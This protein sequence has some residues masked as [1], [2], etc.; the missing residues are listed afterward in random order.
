M[1]ELRALAAFVAEITYD[2]LPD[3]V[4][5]RAKLVLR[6]TVGVI[7]GG[8]EE[9]EVDALAGYAVES[10]P[11]L[12]TLYGHGGKVTPSWAA[13]VHG[14]AGTTLEM[15][16]GHAYAR[17]HAAI[18]ALPPALA[19]AQASHKGGQDTL[20]AFVA[21]Y[22][23]AART[24]IATRLREHV[25]PFGA[26]G[27][28]GAAAVGAR[29]HQ[30]DTEATAGALEVAASYAI[31][32][33]FKTAYQG[34]NVRNTYA[35]LVNRLGLLAADLYAV[36]FRGEAGG[37]QTAFG[38]ILGWQFDPTALVDGLGERFEIL[39]GYFKPYSACRY[40][41]A[42][43]DAVLGLRAAGD[44]D[45]SRVAAIEVQ[46]YDIAAHLND[47][48]PRTALAGRFSLPFVTAAT[49]ATGG[50]GPEIF[51]PQVLR[52][53]QI[54][55]LA[56]RVTVQEDPSF[57]AMTPDQRAARVIV[58]LKNGSTRENTVTGSKG[59]PDQPMSDEE[60]RAKFIALT[61]ASLGPGEAA[62]AWEQLGRI[63]TLSDLSGLGK[64][65]S[66][67]S[68]QMRP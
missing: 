53:P 32:P 45:P 10:H 50:A 31:T 56:A 23:V 1:E 33:S 24:G 36:G 57:T 4:V 66:P 46:T 55:G 19:L 22:E 40:T 37:L 52:D 3:A 17:G 67:D 14:T 61:S 47:P 7:I 44:I 11:G 41:H 12:A 64:L 63:E 35:G 42:A 2:S 59:D 60:L 28:L 39:R 34:A 8:M 65:L 20:V 49:L 43:V 48:E 25:H 21:G 5:T 16:E 6:D 54:L 51:K 68:D 38:E 30:M 27:V 62:R 26:W 15:D 29:F 13:L 9:P 58:R 18:H